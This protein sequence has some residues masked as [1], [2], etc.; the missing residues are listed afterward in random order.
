MVMEKMAE[1]MRSPIGCDM[2]VINADYYLAMGCEEIDPT[3]YV[4]ERQRRMLDY[5]NPYY[6][7]Q[8]AT[9]S[10]ECASWVRSV[11][12]QEELDEFSVYYSYPDGRVNT[13]MEISGKKSFPGTV[14]YRDWN[15][16][17]GNGENQPALKQIYSY[18]VQ[19]FKDAAGQNADDNYVK[20][21]TTKGVLVAADDYAKR[22]YVDAV[23]R[24]SDAQLGFGLNSET[25]FDGTVFR[26][27]GDFARY[28]AHGDDFAAVASR[29]GW[30][31][32]PRWMCSK[33][34]AVLP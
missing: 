18:S 8:F 5:S 20:V 26:N 10:G 28:L 30:R 12:P 4:N 27:T 29:V 1:D 3:E 2:G 11:V 13:V 31:R 15:N 9:R 24:E 21:N 6:I 34:R 16:K 17:L 32:D 14:S 25:R 19:A 22:R 7:R 23:L 33:A